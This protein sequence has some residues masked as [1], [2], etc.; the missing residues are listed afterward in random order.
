M[1]YRQKNRKTIRI[2]KLEREL[3]K[4]MVSTNSQSR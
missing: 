3:L 2:Y 4:I 1:N